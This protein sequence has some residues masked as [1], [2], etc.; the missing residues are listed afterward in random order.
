[1]PWAAVQVVGARLH[2]PALA[3][4]VQM[5]AGREGPVAA[6]DHRDALGRV[7]RAKSDLTALWSAA[8]TSGPDAKA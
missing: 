3:T 4:A 8:G 7:S 2:W 1:M 6:L 5:L